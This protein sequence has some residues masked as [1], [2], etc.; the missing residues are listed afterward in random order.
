MVRLRFQRYGRHNNPF[1]RLAAI[2]GRTRRD[3]PVLE[4]LG[5]YNPIARDETK[6]LEINEERV[7][8]WISKGA[9]PSETVRDILAKRNIGDVKAWEAVRARQR[10]IVEEKKAAAAAAEAAGEKKEEKKA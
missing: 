9:Q 4:N 10:K 2:D 3:G 5:W 8:Y 1:Y 7:K 6:Q